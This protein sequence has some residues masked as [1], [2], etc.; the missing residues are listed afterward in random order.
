[1]ARPADECPYP[2]PFPT[3]FAGCPAYQPR[4]F[5]TYDTLNRPSGAVWTCAHLDVHEMPGSGWGHFYGSCSLGDAAARQHW[6][7]LLG[8]DRLR[9]IESLRQLVL[10]LT[11]ELSRRLVAAKARELVTRPEAQRDAIGL[12][13]EVIGE[14]Y[15]AELQAVLVRQQ[16][17]LDRA[18]MPLALTL[19]LSQNWIRN[20][21]A[22]SSVEL[23]RRASPE[24][25]DRLPDSVRL[26]YGYGP[27]S[28]PKGSPA[29]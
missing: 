17:L 2:K 15:L 29:R 6:A 11:E 5:L 24:L 18:G 16:H 4:Q 7:E 20:F 1:M 12:E 25:V 26:F 10:P 8:T 19:E 3:D 22:G 14:R 23:A 13:M 9:A 21:I 28:V 27:K